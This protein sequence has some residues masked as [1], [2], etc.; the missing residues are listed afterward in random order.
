MGPS[1]RCFLQAKLE[2][3]GEHDNGSAYP[4]LLSRGLTTSRNYTTIDSPINAPCPIGRKQLKNAQWPPPK[5]FCL[6]CHSTHAS[7]SRPIPLVRC[8]GPSI[9]KLKA[10]CQGR[11]IGEARDARFSEYPATPHGA[12]RPSD[13]RIPNRT[14]QRLLPTPGQ[15]YRSAS[16]PVTAASVCHWLGRHWG[17]FESGRGSSMAA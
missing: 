11:Q 9:P 2:E 16:M 4:R 8:T 7:P 5:P 14:N 12:S 10:T 6:F 13:S 15:P 3:R 1:R 17:S